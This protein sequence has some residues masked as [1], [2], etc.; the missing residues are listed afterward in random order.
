[1]STDDDPGPNGMVVA[2]VELVAPGAPAG[3]S[4]EDG[5]LVV[6]LPEQL[7]ERFFVHQLVRP[8]RPL[9]NPVTAVGLEPGQTGGQGKAGRRMETVILVLI[10]LWLLGWLKTLTITLIFICPY[11]PHIMRSNRARKAILIA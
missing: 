4:H 9:E 7:L 6:D 11:S 1:M 2:V 3:M 8:H 10:V 5:G